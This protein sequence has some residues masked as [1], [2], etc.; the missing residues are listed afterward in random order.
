[1]IFVS[2]L[3]PPR[4]QG[5][6]ETYVHS[7]AQALRFL[8]HEVSVLTVEEYDGQPHLSA[9][10]V[11]SR[12]DKY[13][14]L[15][16]RRLF[17]N[18]RRTGQRAPLYDT[19]NPAVEQA[20]RHYMT[21]CQPDIVHATCGMHF[22]ASP[23]I[24]ALGLQL[25]V[26]LTLVTYW[27]VCP[28]SSLLR[29]DGSLCTGR[30]SGLECLG[31]IGGKSRTYRLLTKLPPVV[32]RSVLA[33]NQTTPFLSQLNWGL[34][35]VRAVDHHNEVLA[36]VLSTVDL[37]LA[38]S[39]F[40]RQL[41]IDAGV[42]KYDRIRYWPHGVN[43]EQAK[44][45]CE[46][47]PCDHLR[48]GYTGHMYPFKGVDVLVRAF[49]QIPLSVPASLELHGDVDQMP[50][51]GAK[52][53]ALAAGDPRIRFHGRFENRSIGQVL[54]NIDVLV[55]P[56]VWYE[57]SPIVIHEAH[58][59]QTPVVATN[60]GGMA[61]WVRH[62]VNG[63]LFERGDAADLVRQMQRFIAEPELLPR[64]KAGIRPPLTVKQE[65]VGLVQLYA[66]ISARRRLDTKQNS[67]RQT[68]ADINIADGNDKHYRDNL[69]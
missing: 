34:A 17:Y 56:S 18:R 46:K 66:S 59:A 42:V 54:A 14:G 5:G 51:F 9:T 24:A 21:A 69:A 52:L 26:V 22:S 41:F 2:P 16:I 7:I 36:R 63:L 10:G 6:A 28:I 60:L 55:V 25:P 44:A 38:P 30:K 31:C 68:Q 33:L 47:T 37:L 3:Y 23:V 43:A 19:L 35:M 12:D 64:L 49:R 62:E 13:D 1:M 39:Q 67:C 65:A 8:G 61:D 53:R 58:A 11:E 50:E 20:A 40:L 48:F 15:T 29:P 27:Y 45:G 57:N 4:H 32:R